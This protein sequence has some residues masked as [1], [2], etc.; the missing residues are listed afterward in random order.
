MSRYCQLR[1]PKCPTGRR[2]HSSPDGHL[3][4]EAFEALLVS[5]SRLVSGIDTITFSSWGEPFLNPQ[6]SEIIASAAR[7][8]IRT[9]LSTNLNHRT[10]DFAQRVIDSGLSKMTVAID[11]ATEGTYLRFRRGGDWRLVMRNLE[12]IVRIKADRGVEHPEL[13]WQMVLTRHNHHEIEAA[14]GLSAEHGMRFKLKPLRQ[15][16]LP[17]EATIDDWAP[18]EAVYHRYFGQ[19]EPKHQRHVGINRCEDLWLRP[20]INW[21]GE[22]YP[23]CIVDGREHSLG[24]AFESSL[25]RLWRAEP[26][27][28]SRQLVVDESFS[29]PLRLAC[30]S[31]PH[32]A[33]GGRPEVPPWPT[34]AFG[35]IA[36]HPDTWISTLERA[37]DAGFEHVELR[38]DS[39][40]PDALTTQ[41]RFGA[42]VRA[43]AERLGLSV[44]VHAMDGIDCNEPIG[45]IRRTLADLLVEQL[46]LGERVGARWLTLHVGRGFFRNRPS[47]KKPH[48]QRAAALIREA[49]ERTA[50][51][52]IGVGLENLP[53]KPSDY[54]KCWMGD[55][56]EEL[57]R[58]LA[59]IDSDRAGIVWDFGH[60]H[61]DVPS[62]I[63]DAE[64]AR[65]DTLPLYGIHFH[66]NNG[67]DDA[68]R[69][70]SVEEIAREQAST[71]RSM[72]RLGQ[73]V[74]GDRIAILEIPF[75][76]AVRNRALLRRV[77][78]P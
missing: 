71:A 67:A 16:S 14:R 46:E 4:W 52:H 54:G 33:T 63:R 53:R 43:V 44:S 42:Q 35:V 38:I 45:R 47:K 10:R 60:A 72:S 29:S 75:D 77:W 28:H 50:G 61:L 9:T 27:A 5:N 18:P 3:Q 17:E 25:S 40:E 56:V 26:Y 7:R 36:R 32:R 34:H 6:W 64:M 49:L 62:S 1:C 68:H 78:M 73:M 51:C 13:I 20:N 31:C 19:F 22:I 12:A 39:M 66:Y 48:L 8:G 11:G 76:E 21:D 70:I 74:T 59:E 24:N 69:G 2:L 15:E 23:C 30:A 41:L 37:N 65:A 58:L 55:R 57:E